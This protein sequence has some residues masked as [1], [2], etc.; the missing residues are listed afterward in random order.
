MKIYSIRNKASKKLLGVKLTVTE[1]GNVYY[2]F[3]EDTPQLL[4]THLS[5]GFIQ[6]AIATNEQMDGSYLH[7]FWGMLPPEDYEIV[8]YLPTDN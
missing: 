1:A 7:P 3:S 2:T 6:R 5:I 8:E 4:Y